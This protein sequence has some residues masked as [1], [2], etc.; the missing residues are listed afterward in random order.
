MALGK[1]KNGTRRRSDERAAGEGVWEKKIVHVQ[2][3]MV[4]TFE[5]PRKEFRGRER[6]RG[7]KGRGV[8]RNCGNKTRSERYR[9]V[10]GGTYNLDQHSK[11]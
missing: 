10:R 6:C 2:D 4:C 8:E 3:V 5:Y 1:T 11:P 7:Y 9:R